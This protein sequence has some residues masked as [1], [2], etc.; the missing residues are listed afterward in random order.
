MLPGDFH[1]GDFPEWKPRVLCLHEHVLKTWSK[2]TPP[3]ASVSLLA[4]IKRD[5]RSIPQPTMLQTPPAQPS[6]LEPQGS[7]CMHRA[8]TSQDS[9]RLLQIESTESSTSLLS[10]FVFICFLFSS[11]KLF[12]PLLSETASPLVA[13]RLCAEPLSIAFTFVL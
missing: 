11:W 10:P 7:L 2:V 4:G 8:L 6:R 1:S 12:F 5:S 13:S 9:P 3:Q